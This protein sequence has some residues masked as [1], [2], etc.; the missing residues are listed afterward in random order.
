VSGAHGLCRHGIKVSAFTSWNKISLQNAMRLSISVRY[1]KIE[2]RKAFQRSLILGMGQM[3]HIPPM[4]APPLV[5]ISV[6]FGM[7]S[8]VFRCKK[9]VDPHLHSKISG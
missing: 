6:K 2:L 5:D 7:V 8:N 4:R 9:S 1:H 3:F